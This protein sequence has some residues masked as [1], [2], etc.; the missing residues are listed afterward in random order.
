M[1][2]EQNE[3]LVASQAKNK[4]DVNV[5]YSRVRV[6]KKDSE[7]NNAELNGHVIMLED[8]MQS[9]TAPFPI[10]SLPEILQ[11]YALEA[12]ESICCPVDFITVPLLVLCGGVIGSTRKIELKSDWLEPANLYAV[13]VGDP[14]TK[15]SPALNKSV[16]FVYDLILETDEN[17]DNRRIYTSDCTI[18]AIAERLQKNPRG[19]II[20]RDELTAL[21]RGLNQYKAGKGSDREFL[22]SCWSGSRVVVDRKGKEAIIVDPAILSV[23][24][25]ITPDLLDEIKDQ[26]NREDGMIDRML[27]SYPDPIYQKWSEA[28]VNNETIKR[29][30]ELFQALLALERVD[31][32]PV[33]YT[34]SPEAHR[35]YIKWHDDHYELLNKEEL[36]KMLRGSWGKM[37][38]IVARIA[39]IIHCCQEILY[40]EPQ[41]EVSEKTIT[42]AIAIVEYFKNHAGKALHKI[43]QT[44]DIECTEKI[45]NWAR[46]RGK[47][48]IT[49]R[50]LQRSHVKGCES[51]VEARA[52]ID[53]MEASGL[54]LW[55]E[56]GKEFRLNMN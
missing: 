24:G 33:V 17:Y 23:I 36:P 41:K 4:T 38:G 43:Q 56:S 19:I 44:K 37:S 27:F 45:T 15:K 14:A 26:K 55:N 47:T 54:G 48:V 18:E 20:I 21:M 3:G 12:A 11:S 29:V 51:A 16:Q 9:Q 52:M 34:L 53:V 25:C 2:N 8:Y 13:L 5:N 35:R 31:D 50:D 30:S 40:N 28:E 46:R 32:Q 6:V 39:L 42:N 49:P 1:M 22:L 10:Y 7:Q